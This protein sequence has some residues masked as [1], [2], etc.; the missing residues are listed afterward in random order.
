MIFKKVDISE[1]VTIYKDLLKQFPEVELKSYTR[2]CELLQ[3]GEYFVQIV[4]VDNDP[5]GYVI[6]YELTNS[7]WLDYIA[8]FKESQSKGY[9][10]RILK[11]LSE[12]F[13]K[14][15][16]LEVEKADKNNINTL[17]RIDFYKKLGAKK[18]N[19]EYFYPASNGF[20]PMDLYYL[21]YNN[22]P[23]DI[24]SDI[25]EVFSFIH[26]DVNYIK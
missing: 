2:F 17:R 19:V 4:Q 15:L 24:S 11:S 20:F 14:G 22:L 1:F 7:I 10:S 12:K 9:G 8:I 6:F 23:D 13:Q 25:N 5:I 16:Y 21:P 18:L 3:S 26:S